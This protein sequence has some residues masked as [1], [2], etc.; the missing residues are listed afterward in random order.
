[1]KPEEQL[2]LISKAWGRRKVSDDTYY[3]FFPWI[4]RDEQ[5]EAGIRRAG[6]HE[7]PAFEWPVDREKILAHMEEHRD[8]DLYWCPSLFE[9]PERLTEWAVDEKALW[10]DLDEVDPRT[11]DGYQPTVAW[12]TSP[13][14]YQALWLLNQ[15]DIRGASWEGGENQRLT[16]AIGADESG[17]DTTQLLRIPGWKNHKLGYRKNGKAPVGKLLW[18]NGR[19][20]QADD[21]DDLPT[22]DRPSIAIDAVA[23]DIDHTD[24]SRVMAQW[25][26][27]I[28]RRIRELLNAREP[29]G[30]RSDV[31]WDIERSLADIGCSVTEIV[32]LVR[33][34]VWN[35]Y[36]GRGDELKRLINEA[37]KALAQRPDDVTEA[38]EE[39]S[40][41]KGKPT[42]WNDH[43]KNIKKP[44]MLIKGV[45]TKGKVGFI[46]GQPKSWKSW[47]ALDMAL[48]VST[49]ARYLDYFD[50][51]EPGPVLYIQVED[52]PSTVK[53]RG[54]KIWRG[55]KSDRVKIENGSVVWEPGTEAEFDPAI[56]VYMES[57]VTISEPEW[58]EWLA[59]T[60]REG[61]EGTPYALMIIDTLM[62]VAGDVEENRAQEMTTK[63]FRPLKGLARDH[64]VAVQVVHHLRKGG[65][66]E[67]R[68][69]QL[70]LGSVANHAWSED[71]TYLRLAKAGGVRMEIES[72]FFPSESYRLSGI[73]RGRGWEPTVTE[74][75]DS[76]DP[77]NH[78]ETERGRRDLKGNNDQG[79]TTRYQAVLDIVSEGE[80][81]TDKE[82]GIALGFPTGGYHGQTLKRLQ[83]KGLIACDD[84]R[85]RKWSTV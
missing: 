20:Y 8:E 39:A 13:G 74:W 26:T 80:P 17:W 46:A 64:Q 79:L 4:N 84:S 6:Y 37:S 30:D 15:G 10:A 7:G 41:D 81:I 36:D 48:S 51:L 66:D 75:T 28:P 9:Y 2:D 35:K 42:R 33:G 76:K 40:E 19:R 29:S 71:S 44:E 25:R 11:I 45:L 27:K 47:I 85:P 69:G 83:A 52:D 21:F 34:S 38:L 54:D 63:I 18:K 82:V 1:M 14:R 32:V 31:L 3:C 59:D 5:A 78:Q 16:Y 22:L 58:Q 50:V 49:G 73:D 65:D 67:A 72:K 53:S 12:E 61:F 60:L 77:V 23:T 57:G 70:M 68:G 55:K 43:F 56:A 62:M 24:R